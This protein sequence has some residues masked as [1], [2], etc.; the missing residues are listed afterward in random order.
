M[1]KPQMTKTNPQMTKFS[2]HK[3][4]SETF[5]GVEQKSGLGTNP[6]IPR[7]VSK[8]DSDHGSATTA[9]EPLGLSPRVLFAVGTSPSVT[10]LYSCDPI[11]GL[12]AMKPHHIHL[13]GKV[14]VQSN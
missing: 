9:T 1:T 10:I 12:Y 11:Q 14:L 3:I 6:H 13:Y 5:I 7:V 8:S 2:I 4:I